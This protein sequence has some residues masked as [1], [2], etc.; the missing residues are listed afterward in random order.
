MWAGGFF[1]FLNLPVD[2][3]ERFLVNLIPS[4]ALVMA[5]YWDRVFTLRAEGD[6]R[7]DE[8]LPRI[9]A[10]ILAVLMGGVLLAGPW[11][12]GKRFPIPREA[13]PFSLALVI[14]VSCVAVLYFAR[15]ARLTTVFSGV[16]ALG[17]LMSVG[18]VEFFYPALARYESALQIS[19]EVRALV[20]D[21][22]L[23]LSYS[24][25]GAFREEIIY[26]L[27]SAKPLPRMRSTKE[28]AAAL[29]RDHT[30]FG[31]LHRDRFDEL[32]A[33]TEAVPVKVKEF[34]YRRRPF[35]LVKN[36]P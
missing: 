22:P 1:L 2:K 29:R 11:I 10:G 25:D 34:S 12:L 17:M 32:L 36:R 31:L 20:G 26:Y 6:R 13:W 19:Q 4:F 23:V 5:C 27:D 30:V 24:S 7:L 28:L 8:R 9:T 35:V 3:A 18:L 14:G 15:C 33:Q 21:A 16:L